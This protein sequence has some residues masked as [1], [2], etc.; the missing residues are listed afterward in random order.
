MAVLR[1]VSF[2]CN[3]NSTV[4]RRAPQKGASIVTSLLKRNRKLG[5]FL[6]YPPPAM[7]F[8]PILEPP[9]EETL[10][11]GEDIKNSAQKEEAETEKQE[12]APEENIQK[13]KRRRMKHKKQK[14]NIQ[15]P[16]STSVSLEALPFANIDIATVLE[17]PNTLD[18]KVK[19]KRKR[20]HVLENEDEDTSKKQKRANYFISLPITNPKVLGAIEIFQ[21]AV[22]QKDERLS[23]AMIPKGSFHL[24]LFVM[25]LANEDEVNLAVSALF[26]SK[27]SIEEILQ[28]KELVCSFHGVDEFKH[29]VVYGKM[30]EGDFVNSL[31]RIADT[32]EKIFKEKGIVAAGYKG[33]VPHLTFMKL[34]RAPKL[35]KQGLKKI[36]PSLYKDFQDHQFGDEILCRIDLCSM[37]KQ[38]QP[39]GYYHTEA[40]IFFANSPSCRGPL[41]DS[42]NF[43]YVEDT[44][45]GLTVFGHL[46][47]TP[48]L[49]KETQ[50][51]TESPVLKASGLHARPS[52]DVSQHGSTCTSTFP[53][54]NTTLTNEAVNLSLSDSKKT[55]KV[56]VQMLPLVAG[57]GN[58]RRQPVLVDPHK[59]KQEHISQ[60][61]GSTSQPSL[62][63]LNYSCYPSQLS[64]QASIADLVSL[65]RQ[66]LEAEKV[67]QENNEKNMSLLFERLTSIQEQQ[68]YTNKNLKGI[69]SELSSIGKQLGQ[70]VQLFQTEAVVS[71]AFPSGPAVHAPGDTERA[72]EQISVKKEIAEDSETL[73]V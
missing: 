67:Q 8:F 6:L 18:K 10:D 52:S 2:L 65:Q 39:G 14:P 63:Q 37:V 30:T 47:E 57:E 68:R 7:E 4:T 35:R 5:D 36:D 38:R 50:K 62:Q 3:F 26:E 11:M 58:F 31:K 23:R 17:I 20:K 73:A 61:V 45:T 69:R 48:G 15:E 9:P 1:T 56:E 12:N 70:I 41:L 59:V 28:G 34:S 25:H 16:M 49:S 40:S 42:R 64:S 46:E 13:K 22:L 53:V 43:R 44:S 24:T 27:E 72:E 54:F 55:Q 51:Q 66:R 32:M 29:E 71:R 60:T 33:L 19:K 21:E